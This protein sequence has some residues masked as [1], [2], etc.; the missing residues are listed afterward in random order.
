MYLMV[1]FSRKGPSSLGT[2]RYDAEKT[3]TAAI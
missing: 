2:G 1:K 3:A